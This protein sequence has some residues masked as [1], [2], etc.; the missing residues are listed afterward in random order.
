[1]GVVTIPQITV[2]RRDANF[3]EEKAMRCSLEREIQIQPEEEIL[4]PKDDPREVVEKPHMEDQ[5]GGRVETSTQV[6]SSR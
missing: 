3:D 5:R 6:E 1:M 2:V 4:A